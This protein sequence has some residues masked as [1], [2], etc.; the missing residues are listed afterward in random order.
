M[1]PV[2]FVQAGGLPGNT[3]SF[4]ADRPCAAR[5]GSWA[6]V[7]V[8]RVRSRSSSRQVAGLFDVGVVAEREV[9]AVHVHATQRVAMPFPG[10]EA[11]PHER[12]TPGWRQLQPG[13]GSRLGERPA[14]AL[15]PAESGG[16]CPPTV[17]PAPGCA[18][19]RPRR[20]A[21]AAAGASAGP[22]HAGHR[23]RSIAQC[24]GGAGF[25]ETSAGCRC[26][27]AAARSGSA[28]CR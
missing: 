2:S 28:A 9:A 8:G 16:S 10:V 18:T 4:V 25:T 15:Q 14:E 26:A 23:V 13:R 22:G 24:S 21:A 12:F 17:A 5:P 19:W 20:V 3:S 27:A 7:P 11:G 1:R 6:A